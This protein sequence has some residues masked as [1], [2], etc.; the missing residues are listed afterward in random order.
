MNVMVIP[1]LVQRVN[2]DSGLSDTRE[3]AFGT[4]AGAAETAERTC[5]VRD[6]VLGLTKEFLLEVFKEGV[7]EILTTEMGITGG[8][9]D[10]KDT[11]RDV[12]KGHIEGTS[13]KVEDENV[14]LSLFLTVKTV[15]DGGCCGLVDNTKNV[16]T[17]D[18]ASILGGE[19]LGVV[20]VRRDTE[21]SMSC[22]NLLYEE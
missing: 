6:V 4:L 8:G 14:L 12:E 17:S 9:L 2:L 13:A 22:I 7:I 21:E 5:I 3:R 19:T 1:N 16:E 11:T 10:G 15:G 18:G 20:E